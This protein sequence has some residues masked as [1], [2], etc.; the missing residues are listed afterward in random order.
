MEEPLIKN[1][2]FTVTRHFLADERG[3]IEVF[4]FDALAHV[5]GGW[6]WDP[7]KGWVRNLPFLDGGNCAVNKDDMGA[8][9]IFRYAR[10][11]WETQQLAN[12]SVTERQRLQAAGDGLYDKLFRFVIMAL[13]IL[14][15]IMPQMMRG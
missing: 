1:R 7:K 3:M 11:Y 9:E 6:V 14:F 4:S 8:E 2:D 15:V 10:Q 12:R 5:K 13:V